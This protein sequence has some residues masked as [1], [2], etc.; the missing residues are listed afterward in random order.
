MNVSF[1]EK[2]MRKISLAVLLSGVIF[3][4]IGEMPV[5]AYEI[6]NLGD[7][8]TQR[9]FVVGPGK[10]ELWMDPGEKKTEHFYITNRLGQ[11]MTFKVKLEDF[12]GSR[13]PAQTTV[14]LGEEKGPYSLRDYLKPEITEFT[15]KH[16]ERM[17]LPVEIS[18]P[19]D[20]E[21]GG[22]YGSVLV[23]TNPPKAALQEEKEKAVTQMRVISQIST[24][25]FIRVK[26]D[27]K[28]EGLLTNL[29]ADKVEKK[30][31][32]K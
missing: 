20:A 32:E 21:P 28:E 10:I 17:I 18:I 27:V 30:F 11:E 15:L 26:G 7:V 1:A 16:G 24:L 2:I 29:K 3:F 19:K 23:S 9:D 13:D 25:L 4:G 5:F 22:L 14:L 8:G 12:K 31:Y 6:Q